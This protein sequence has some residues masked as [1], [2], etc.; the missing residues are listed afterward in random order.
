M[1][2]DGPICEG[3][4]L[5]QRLTALPKEGAVSDCLPCSVASSFFFCLPHAHFWRERKRWLESAGRRVLNNIIYY[6]LHSEDNSSAS[7][8]S[9]ELIHFP[10]N[11]RNSHRFK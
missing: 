8:P 9:R 3:D 4:S 6:D 5:K 11:L 1:G 10:Y 7:V 2:E